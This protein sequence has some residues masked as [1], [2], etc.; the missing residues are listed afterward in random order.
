MM[1]LHVVVRG[2]VQ[3]VGF[4]WFAREQGRILGVRGWVRNRPDGGVEVSADGDPAKLESFL[5]RLAEG[6]A[7]AVVSHVEQ[8]E[9]A[10]EE[11]P[12]PFTILR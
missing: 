12:N 3:G 9:V 6:P 7:G 11:L 5:A 8:L 1:P 2:R 10:A 4:R